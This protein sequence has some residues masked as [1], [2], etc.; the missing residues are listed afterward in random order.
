M[1]QEDVQI[2]FQAGGKSA[3]LECLLELQQA[4]LAQQSVLRGSDPHRFPEFVR[5]RV[6]V[7]VGAACTGSAVLLT[8][9]RAATSVHRRCD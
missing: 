9:M 3:A 6:V 1:N 7:F 4:V 8:C 5:Y 2:A